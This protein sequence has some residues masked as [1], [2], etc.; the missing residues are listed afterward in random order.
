MYICEDYSAIEKEWN[1]VDDNMNELW[2]LS[3]MSD[4]KT[5]IL[6]DLIYMWTLKIKTKAKM[7]SQVQAGGCQR[8]G[9]LEAKVA[10]FQF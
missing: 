1:L 4:R 10:N 8:Q 2:V 3:E 7:N 5:Q 6:H 9:E